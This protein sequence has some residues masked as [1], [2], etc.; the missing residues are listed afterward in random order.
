MVGDQA[1]KEVYDLAE[2]MNKFGPAIIVLAVFILIFLAVM[3][4]FIRSYSNSTKSSQD[5]FSQ[6]MQQQQQVFSYLLK[7]KDNEEAKPVAAYD[8]KKIVEIFCRL[9]I[10]LKSECKKFLDKTECDRIGVYVFHNGTVASHG[11]PFFKVSCICECIKRG[12][13]I[14]SHITDSTNLPLNLFGDIVEKLYVEPG[15]CVVVRNTIDNAFHSDSFFLE[16]DKAATAIFTVVY[17]SEDNIMAFILGEYRSELTEEEIAED[18]AIY[19]ELCA[20]LKMVLEF[21][22]YQKLRIEN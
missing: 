12:S 9:N 7:E 2:A 8:E 6:M 1:L 20:R 16:K 3:L 22:E 19:K 17:D 10:H 13:G 21:S 4:L 14:C 5:T 11:L 15:G 18:S